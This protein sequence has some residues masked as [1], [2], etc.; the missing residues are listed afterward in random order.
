MQLSPCRTDNV[1]MALCLLW[2]VAMYLSQ[3]SQ[4]NSPHHQ[5]LCQE[6][7]LPTSA[8]M[9]PYCIKLA[10]WLYFI[11]LNFENYEN[12]IFA[13]EN[14]GGPALPFAFMLLIDYSDYALP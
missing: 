2:H 6:M 7:P 12:N 3:L 13:I 11:S 8:K 10:G 14:L 1:D 5:I 4:L 9:V